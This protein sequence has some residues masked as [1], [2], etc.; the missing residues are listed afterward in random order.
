MKIGI[1]CRLWNETGIGRYIRNLIINLIELDGKNE[2]VLFMQNEDRPKLKVNSEKL[3]V[4]GVDIKWHTLEEQLRFPQI[5]NRENLDLMHF[6]YFSVPV[7]YNRP[8]VVTIHDLILNHF[9]TGQAS[10][11]PGPIYNIKLLAYKFILNQEAKKAKKIIAVSNATKNEIIDHLKINPQK[12]T[13][14]YEGADDKI[15]NFPTSSRSAGLRGASKILNTKYFLY[16][17]NAYPHKNLDRLLKAFSDLRQNDTK[18]VL[19]GKEDYFYKRLKNKAQSL[20]LSDK[21]IFLQNVSD[22]ELSNLYQNALALIMPSL[23]EGFGLPALEAMANNCLVLASNIPSL[24]E[25]CGDAALYF[26]P[27]SINELADKL[28]MIA[29]HNTEYKELEEI[30]KRGIERARKFS[31]QKMARETLK[32]YESCVGL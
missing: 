5:L 23:M 30:R 17:G 31:W 32:V 1:D 28:S 4:V 13:V 6:P 2:Y 11:L 18:L 3:K 20:R 14:T 8:F 26:N 15:S 19:I 10:T 7:F 29:I 22:K 27:L 25:V 12:I 24:K 16:V 21:V 9:P